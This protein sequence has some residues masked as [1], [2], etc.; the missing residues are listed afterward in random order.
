MKLVYCVTQSEFSD[1]VQK[2]INITAIPKHY[3]NKIEFQAYRLLFSVQWSLCLGG[4][5]LSRGVSVG[6]SPPVDRQT[7]VKILPYPKLRLG[8]VKIKRYQYV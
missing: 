1:F 5:S 7:P 4:G 6:G 8:V 2:S 3:L